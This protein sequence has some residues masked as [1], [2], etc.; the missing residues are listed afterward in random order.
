MWIFTG[1]SGLW[2][3]LIAC[4]DLI[5]DGLQS[6]LNIWFSHYG[7]LSFAVLHKH[8]KIEL[9]FGFA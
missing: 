3:M 9:C 8:Q 6:E 2:I 1:L 4:K 5:R 7:F